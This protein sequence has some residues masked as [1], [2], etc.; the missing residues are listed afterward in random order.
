M[1]VG[2]G[3][4]ESEIAAQERDGHWSAGGDHWVSLDLYIL[5]S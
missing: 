3:G 1:G 4:Q 5:L 2:W